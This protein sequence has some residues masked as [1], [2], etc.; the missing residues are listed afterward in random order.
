MPKVEINRLVLY[1]SPLSEHVFVGD[2]R[3]GKNNCV[4]NKKDV[5]SDFLGCIIDFYGGYE[6]IITHGED[7][8]KIT[9]KKVSGIKKGGK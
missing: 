1:K 4:N 7:T 5:T 2:L 8:Y 6:G 3:K 9:V